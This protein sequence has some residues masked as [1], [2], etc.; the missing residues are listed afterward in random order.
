MTR[1]RVF[2]I[3]QAVLCALV[4]TLLAAAAIGLYIEGTAGQA[5]TGS[6]FS[7]IYTREKV[8]AR[9]SPILPLV[10][11]SLGMTA[12]GW[13]LGIREKETVGRPMPGL[14]VK[15]SVAQKAGRPALFMRTAFL[16]LAAALI[17]AGVMNGG[18]E[19]VFTKAAAIC[20]ECIGLG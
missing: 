17:A 3:V 4:A 5:E 1:N 19:D 16:I 11:A 20:M 15:K 13:I 10:F 2:L 14:A 18:L 8:T 7:Y 6:L 9:L 12:A